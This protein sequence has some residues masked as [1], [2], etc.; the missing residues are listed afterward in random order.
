MAR[1]GKDIV[2]RRRHGWYEN[3]TTDDGVRH[4]ATLATRDRDVARREARR[5]LRHINRTHHAAIVV[6][7]A[8]A[9]A[10][11]IAMMPPVQRLLPDEARALLLMPRAHL[12]ELIRTGE[13]R[14]YV[15][16]AIRAAL[17][18]SIMPRETLITPYL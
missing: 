4:R 10:A 3:F 13:L 7:E 5:R 9:E 8:E 14:L 15:T 18:L 16:A 17:N 11:L 6:R 2:Q 12:H 1:R